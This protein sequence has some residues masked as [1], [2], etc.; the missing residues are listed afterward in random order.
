MD[1]G[2]IENQTVSKNPMP[3]FTLPDNASELSKN[4]LTKLRRKY[5]R[6]LKSWEMREANM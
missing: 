3:V 4:T 6:Q 5:K 1:I 2:G